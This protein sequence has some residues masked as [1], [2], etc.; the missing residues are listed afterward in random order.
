MSFVAGKGLAG[1]VAGHDARAFLPAMLEREET[2][3]SQ[4]RG[5]RMTEDREDAALVLGKRERA[6]FSVSTAGSS[7]IVSNHPLIESR[8]N[9][10]NF[11]QL[12]TGSL[13]VSTAR[14]M[15]LNQSS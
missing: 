5:V 11:L 14:R 10:D 6:G 12:R 13:S 3:I 2:V 15:A 9:R 1:A 4:H 8:I 7:D